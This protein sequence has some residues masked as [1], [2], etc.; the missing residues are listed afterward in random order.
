M[1]TH[2]YLSIHAYL[3]LSHIDPCSNY[4]SIPTSIHNTHTHTHMDTYTY[5][6]NLTL[7][8]AIFPNINA[9]SEDLQSRNIAI[10]DVF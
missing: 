5:L 6:S 3:R 10:Q 9:T 8:G 2:T 4:S 7:H 1:N